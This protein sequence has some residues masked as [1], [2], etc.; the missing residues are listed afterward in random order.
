MTTVDV[1]DQGRDAYARQAW[2]DAY[3]HLSA[4]DRAT[5]L[6]PDDLERLATAAYLTG[7]EAGAVA[8]LTR[9]YHL[10][11][12]REEIE[13]A[14]RCG[15][16]LSHHL[17]L[18]GDETPSRGWLSRT[19]RLLDD[20][21][22]DCLERGY[23]LVIVALYAIGAKDAAGSYTTSC[24]L[25]KIAEQFGDPD[26]ATFGLVCR[27]KA[28]IELGE[29][30]EAMELLDE[31]IV[32]V[33]SREVSP[34]A[35]G[36]VCCAAI[37]A[38]RNALDLGRAHR[39][40]AV[41]S[42]W[43]DAQPDL[44][45]FRGQ[46]LVHR[47]EI[48]QLRGTWRDALEE[49]R[50]ACARLAEPTEQPALGMAY[51]QRAELHRLRGELTEAEE[52]YRAAHQHGREPQPGLALLRLAQGQ[53]AAAETTIR[54]LAEQARDAM[55][56]VHVLAACVEI[57]LAV[58]DVAAARSAADELAKLAQDRDVPLLRGESAHAAGAVL[59]AEGDPR[60]ALTALQQARATW[61]ELDAPYQAAR[62]GVLAGLA[63]RRLGDDDTAHLEW[64]AARE[65]FEKL[66]ARP[67]LARLAELAS[68]GDGGGDGGLT[69]RERQ[70]LGLVAV[71]RSNREVAGELVISDK[72]VERHLSNIF[73]K[74]GVSNRAGATAYA[75]RHG[76]V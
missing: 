8:V 1:L 43:C 5:P 7:D 21:Q 15:F 44:V 23:L 49:V 17:L 54:R 20:R 37:L 14:A 41:L 36:I 70:I 57:L 18:A 64:D 31:A 25:S 52:C 68:S 32:A 71:G 26:L 46:C 53:A 3:T 13:R 62:V 16:W 56:R 65:V 11:I 60:A 4:A 74:I 33:A 47:S 6:G 39:W 29:T 58:G 55:S 63:C 28:L 48:M 61:Q 72:T 50:R 34:I 66:G 38:C 12:D 76:L 69:P 2:A 42:E 75:Y 19:Q 35:S 45:P 24:Q 40:T 59:L 22:L 51:Y 30:A 73:T 27:G 67:D 10:L 9:A